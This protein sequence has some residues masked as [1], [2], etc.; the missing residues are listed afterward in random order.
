MVITGVSRGLGRAEAERFL[1]KGYHVVGTVRNQTDVDK[2]K[3]EVGDRMT[4][5]IMDIRDDQ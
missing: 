2:W 4:C 3:E 1:L 5:L